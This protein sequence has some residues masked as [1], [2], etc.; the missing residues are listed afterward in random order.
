VDC[1]KASEILSMVHDGEFDDEPLIAEARAHCDDCASCAAFADTLE[2]L[3]TLPAPEAPEHLVERLRV[4][5][6]KASSARETAPAASE[7]LA[8]TARA[9]SAAVM[10]MAGGRPRS[11]Q[12]FAGFIT[13][14]ALLIVGSVVT[15]IGINR[16]ADTSDSERSATT[17]QESDTALGAAP[18]ATG[19][20]SAY[21]DGSP[22]YVIYDGGVFVLG[23]DSMPS[24]AMDQA[25]TVSSALDGGGTPVALLTLVLQGG[26]RA[27]QIWV[28]RPDGSFLPFKRVVRLL[29]G[30]SFQLVSDPV[31]DSFGIWP[32]LPSRFAPPES[33]D[34]GPT[35][36]HAGFDDRGVDI[37]APVGADASS[38]FAVRPGTAADDPAASNPNWTWWEPLD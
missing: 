28:E 7:R 32:T 20:S 17:A 15:G 11:Q 13:V 8:Q 22:A 33:T 29:G 37:Y 16:M 10:A 1:L 30:R 3:A 35:F 34:G 14:A 38:G 23:G 12:R 21:G 25:G 18:M 6:R 31:L 9:K 24:S 26:Q 19:E 2:H 27:D 4:L 36:T 5:G